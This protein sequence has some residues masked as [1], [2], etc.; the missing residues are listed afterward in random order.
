MKDGSCLMIRRASRRQNAVMVSL[1]TLPLLLALVQPITSQQ[2]V[3][4][5]TLAPEWMN[6]T[7][8]TPGASHPTVW[9]EVPFNMTDQRMV[10]RAQAET[11][12]KKNASAGVLDPEA[13]NNIV[14]ETSTNPSKT[15]SRVK[16][17]TSQLL[18]SSVTAKGGITQPKWSTVTSVTTVPTL[19]MGGHSEKETTTKTSNESKGEDFLKVWVSST[20]SQTAHNILTTVS[21]THTKPTADPAFQLKPSTAPASRTS[22]ITGANLAV[23]QSSSTILTGLPLG[24]SPRSPSSSPSPNEGPYFHTSETSIHLRTTSSPHPAKSTTPSEQSD[25]TGS[26]TTSTSSTSQLPEG[27]KTSKS[28]TSVRTAPAQQNPADTT[29]QST[30]VSVGRGRLGQ[31][32]SSF[33]FGHVPSAKPR[34]TKDPCATDVTA[35]ASPKDLNVPAATSNRTML[36]WADLSRK[37]SFAWELHVFGSAA[38]FLLLS[39]GSALGLALAPSM[40]C[41][42]RGALALANGLL[43]LAGVV[44]ATFFLVDPYGSHAIM[45]LHVMTALYT[46][47][48]PL[49]IWVQAAMVVLVL[50]GAEVVLLRPSFQRVPLL[51]LLAVLQLCCLLHAYTCLWL[52]GLLGNWRH[53]RWA[54]WLVQFWARLLELAWAFCLLL[55]A[56]WVFWRPRGSQT[57]RAPGHGVG[58]AG[59]Q[60]SSCPSSSS[61]QTHTCWAKIVQSLKSRPYRKSDSN[62]I[63]GASG[64][65]VAGELPNNW[66]G[67]ERPG[68][69]IS[70]SLIRNRDQPKESNHGRN[71]RSIDAS[72]GSLPRLQALGRQRQYSQS[73]SLDRDKQSAISLYEFDLRPPSP[74]DL[75]RSIDEALHREHLLRGGS[76]FRPLGSPSPPPSPGNWM[77]RSSDP[78]IML[79][80]SSDEHTLLS[81]SSAGLD[82][83][84]PSAVPSRQVTAPPTPTHQGPRWISE[85]AVPNSIS[86]PVSLHPSPS[87]LGRALT[88]STDDTRPF[89]TPDVDRVGSQ[90]GNGD[91][92]Y[93]TV[94]RHDDSA[95]VSSDIIDL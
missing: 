62:G 83:P 91:R 14:R 50:K 79:S 86:C 27:S 71:Q 78:Q 11:G 13:V 30:T 74:I 41:P 42:H 17:T 68:A 29:T 64:G 94:R 55:L 51:A 89:L 69:D 40:N 88:P 84:I 35:C 67:Q 12:A 28:L 23:V 15:D 16:L 81:E 4:N 95:S 93:L 43:F 22:A 1:L 59:D 58:P 72:S 76:L 92:G 73:G 47:P 24:Q 48:L 57:S 70:K 25:D 34:P 39:A 21:D 26:Q 53:F 85:A 8:M 10:T 90:Q 31:K 56:S 46:L 32:E 87:S 36:V 6:R 18:L 9:T 5:R 54:W 2:Q 77:R 80:E 3:N 20:V 45:P 66:A 82:R 60:S 7:Q 65:G 75:S 44:R 33:S 38:L 61:S 63:G 19:K 52:Y 37:L 49:F